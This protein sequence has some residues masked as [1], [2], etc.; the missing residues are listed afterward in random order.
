M[1]PVITV[2]AFVLSLGCPYVRS[3]DLALRRDRDGD[4]WAHDEDCDDFDPAIHPG[5]EDLRDGVD[6]DCDGVVDEETVPAWE[7]ADD[8]GFGVG[9][10]DSPAAWFC[11]GDDPGAN[12][13]LALGDCDDTRPDVYPGATPDFEGGAVCDDTDYD[14]DGEVE[15]DDDHDGYAHT[16]CGGSDADDGDPAQVEP[17]F[18]WIDGADDNLDGTVDVHLT[19]YPDATIEGTLDDWHLGCSVSMDRDLNADGVDDLVIGIKRA[20]AAD[21]HGERSLENA[22]AVWVIYGPV[23]AEVVLDPD[24]AEDEAIIYGRQGYTDEDD[25]YGDQLGTQVLAVGDQSGDG[26]DD[27]LVLAR[28]EDSAVDGDPNVGAAHLLLGPLGPGQS[29]D[30]AVA[31]FYG[32]SDDRSMASMLV[33]DMDGD[34]QGDGVF[35]CTNN[36][37][38][39][40][41]GTLHVFAGPFDDR[42]VVSV[43]QASVEI[44]GEEERDRIGEAD[45]ACVLDFDGDGLDDIA[46]GSPYSWRTTEDAN[47]GAVW[48][49]PGPL[50]FGEGGPTTGSLSDFGVAIHGEAEDEGVGHRVFSGGDVDQDGLDDLLVTGWATGEGLVGVGSGYVVFGHD[51]DEDTALDASGPLDVTE[52]S[53]TV[54]DERAGNLLVSV[55][56]LDRD[57]FPDIM[58]GSTLAFTVFAGSEI[59]RGAAIDTTDSQAVLQPEAGSLGDTL[60]PV[61]AQGGDVDG[62][63]IGDFA[64][65]RPSADEGVGHIS[66]FFGAQRG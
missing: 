62:D 47:T 3:E 13:A 29:L 50:T 28:W 2:F 42:G 23:G 21:E 37:L 43:E 16:W 1:V 8:D 27:L 7:D 48:V 61:P 63:G 64:I 32:I 66:F 17:G 34:R 44:R 25:E 20:D 24:A 49:L 65:P 5:A 33:G 4:G 46:V 14:C 60:L 56:D 26:R 35:G 10:E 38:K 45:R 18:D 30:D 40:G 54:E 11:V 39:T 36:E 57:T 41:F 55:G 9:E 58:M 6:N 12:L 51:L 31:S 53:G 22:G 52:I 19:D 59:P 15:E